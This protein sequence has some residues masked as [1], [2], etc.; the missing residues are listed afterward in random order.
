LLSEMKKERLP[1]FDPATGAIVAILHKSLINGFLVK[2]GG[3]AFDTSTL[4]QLLADVDAGNVAKQS[5]AVIPN[6]S[7]LAD[8]KEAMLRQQASAKV[9]CEDAFI[10][11]PGG[12]R[13]EGWITNDIIDKNSQA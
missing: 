5:F 10:T 1:L 3:A 11:S 4:E 12:T 8:A 13:V 9:S 7:T 6:T 2:K